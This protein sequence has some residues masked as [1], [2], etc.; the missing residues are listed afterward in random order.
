MRDR[1]VVAV[2]TVVL[3]ACGYAGQS[4]EKLDTPFP[5]HLVGMQARGDGAC[6][7]AP[8]HCVI[9]Y[10]VRVTNPTDQ[11]ANVLECQLALPGG[12]SPAVNVT[13]GIGAPAGTWVPAG[14]TRLGSGYQPVPLGREALAS[15]RRHSSMSCT[16]LDWH[17][18]LPL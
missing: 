1:V 9:G 16:G 14:S 3:G 18:H 6:G 8:R 2:L 4:A 17:G 5:G 12:S 15:L 10:R 11:D 13:L 7:V